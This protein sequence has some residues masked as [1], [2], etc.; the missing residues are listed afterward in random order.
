MDS[1]LFFA[2]LY[3]LCLVIVGLGLMFNLKTYQKMIADFFKNAALVY[4][5]GILALLIGLIVVINHNLWVADWRA[6]ITV[7]GWAGFIKGVWLIVFP[8]TIAAFTEVYQRKTGLLVAHA[9]L[10]LAL[11]LFLAFKGYFSSSG[12]G[13]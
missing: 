5:G 11:G 13:L 6:V 9:V 10:V 12:Y 8:R 4:L 3:G 2:K 1:S 7:L